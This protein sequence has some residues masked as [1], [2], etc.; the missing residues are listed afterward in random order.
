[1]NGKRYVRHAQDL[2][3]AAGLFRQN[4]IRYEPLFDHSVEAF[5]VL[6]SSAGSLP[7][8]AT[9][10]GRACPVVEVAAGGDGRIVLR[11]TGDQ[12]LVYELLRVARDVAPPQGVWMHDARHDDG[13]LRRVR[14]AY[15]QFFDP[16]TASWSFSTDDVLSTLR[17]RDA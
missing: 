5:I 17:R 7:S 15:E 8:L 11:V 6:P 13:A 1:V 10:F 3:V 12:E 2:L 4:I 14:F 16:V 9:M